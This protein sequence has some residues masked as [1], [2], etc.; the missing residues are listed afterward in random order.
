MVPSLSK[1]YI[2]EL[3]LHLRWS[4]R[5][6]I[7]LPNFRATDQLKLLKTALEATNFSLRRTWTLRK[8]TSCRGSRALHLQQGKTGLRFHRVCR[9]LKNSFKIISQ[10]HTQL[11]SSNKHIYLLKDRTNLSQSRPPS[12]FIR[13][14][15]QGLPNH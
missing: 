6:T 3:V 4:I 7:R 2:S 11:S 1:W 10:V 8:Y 15:F 13:S 5:I 14:S 9:S 12:C